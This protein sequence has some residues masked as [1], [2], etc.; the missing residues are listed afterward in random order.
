MM[1]T[2]VAV[3]ENLFGTIPFLEYIGLEILRPKRGAGDQSIHDQLTLLADNGSDKVVFF[4]RDKDFL[5][6]PART[7]YLYMMTMK[8]DTSQMDLARIIELMLNRDLPGRN[9]PQFEVRLRQ[10]ARVRPKPGMWELRKHQMVEVVAALAPNPPWIE[11]PTWYQDR[12]GGWWTYSHIDDSLEKKGTGGP[13]AV[14]RCVDCQAMAILQ[15]IPMI[16]A[17]HSYG[18]AHHQTCPHSHIV[19]RIPWKT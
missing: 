19:E 1:K 13:R 7:Y 6:Y 9:D 17:Q 5:K 10:V 16:N 8:P 4:T 3:D 15:D 12:M 2:T 11:Q 18:A 14:F